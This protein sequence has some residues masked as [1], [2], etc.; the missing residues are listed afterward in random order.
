M[1]VSHQTGRRIENS[2]AQPVGDGQELIL[3]GPDRRRWEEKRHSSIIRRRGVAKDGRDGDWD[4]GVGRFGEDHYQVMV[5]SPITRTQQR[6]PAPGRAGVL[7][8]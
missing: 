3:R 6:A 7:A 2:V 5:A 4:Q 1:Y 8:H